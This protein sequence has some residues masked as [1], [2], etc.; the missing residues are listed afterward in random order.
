MYSLKITC[1]QCAITHL[2]IN[3]QPIDV[4]DLID[5]AEHTSMPESCCFTGAEVS[6][7]TGQHCEGLRRTRLNHIR[8]CK[9]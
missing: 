5:K 8:V 6:S 2:Q 4:A 7:S 3:T 1:C 9:T